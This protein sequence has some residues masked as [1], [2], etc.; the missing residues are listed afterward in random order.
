M[1]ANCQSCKHEYICTS[2][3]K[4]RQQDRPTDCQHYAKVEEE[5]QR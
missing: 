5:S 2:L 3:Y 4:Q 1:T